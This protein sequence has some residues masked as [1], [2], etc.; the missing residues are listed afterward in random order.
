MKLIQFTQ[1][2]IIYHLLEKYIIALSKT[3]QS[4]VFLYIQYFF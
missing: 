3:K 1:M 4:P 2:L